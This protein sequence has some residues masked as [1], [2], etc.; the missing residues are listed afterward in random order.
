MPAL[1]QLIRLETNGDVNRML[2][3][4]GGRGVSVETGAVHDVSHAVIYKCL[5]Q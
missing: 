4:S 3:D 5:A 2:R 1:K